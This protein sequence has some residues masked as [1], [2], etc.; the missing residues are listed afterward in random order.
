MSRNRL[1]EETSPYL[2]QHADNP[3]DWWPWGQPALAAAAA[4]D[5]PILLSVGYAACHWCHVMAH[6][7]FENPEIAATMNRLFINIKVDREERPDLD[8]IYQQALALLGE[9]GGWPL[10]MFLTPSGQPFWGGTYFPPVSRWGRP[11]FPDVLRAIADTW[12]NEPAK[13]TTNVDALK[14]ALGQLNAAQPGGPLPAEIRERIAATLLREVDATW[15]GVGGAPK[16]PQPYVLENLWRAWRRTGRPGFV[17]AHDLTLTQMC[18]G[19]IYDHLG[20]GFARYAT[21]PQ[22]LVPHFE[23][24]L[25]DNAQ[26]IDQLTVRALETGNPLYEARLRETVDW[27]LGEMVAEG[28][29]FAASLDAD[30]EG[31]EGRFYVWTEEAVKEAI[32]DEALFRLFSRHYEVTAGGNWEDKVILNR[33]HMRTLGDPETEASLA[34]ARA[35]LLRVRADRVRPGWDDKI[36]TDWNCLMIYTLAWAGLAYGE[37]SWVDA[38]TRAYGFIQTH[39]RPGGRLHHSAR[40]GR[41]QH[42]GTLD[43]HAGMVRAGIALFAATGDSRYLREARDMAETA[44]DL[45]A[46]PQGGFYTTARDTD[47]LVVRPYGATDNAVPSG[48]GVIATAFADLFLLTGEARWRD[49]AESTIAAFSGGIERNFFPLM[50]L[51]NAADRLETGL[52]VTVIGERD[53]PAARDLARMAITA[54]G[55][56]RLLVWVD[57]GAGL[58]QGHPAAGKGLIDGRPAAYVCQSMSCR[59]PVGDPEMLRQE[60]ADARPHHDPVS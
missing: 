54:M 3:V 21:D 30:S 2:L 28:G 10:T 53:D 6:E 33:R 14:E 36:L 27:V 23:K 34:D 7:S 35:R 32:G 45:F 59:P 48:N 57:D 4:A 46:A 12:A 43:D 1:A 41:V 19:G 44:I 16:F 47:D 31:E 40:R 18:Q 51:I 55:H 50:T 8:Q 15:G 22:W 39:M 60:I 49:L 24:M 9:Q 42:P 11:G 52:Q 26:L 25:Y 5:R 56:D 20:G 13:V 38:A 58:P 17:D 37:S 29:G